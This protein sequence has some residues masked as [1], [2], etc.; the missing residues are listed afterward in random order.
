M[1]GQLKAAMS[2]QEILAT[3]AWL[4]V[5][6]LA[7][8]WGLTRQGAF[9]RLTDRDGV[10]FERAFRN[11]GQWYIETADFKHI[12]SKLKVGKYYDVNE[13]KM[14]LSHPPLK[15]EVNACADLVKKKIEATS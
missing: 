1:P 6:M 14:A 3:Q 13:R 12:V 15:D 9:M 5:A 8:I 11:G 10:W 4:S 2:P 7:K